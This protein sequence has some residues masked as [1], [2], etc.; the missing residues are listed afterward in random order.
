[1]EQ[2]DAMLR[3]VE[4]ADLVLALI[5]NP[6]YAY[7]GTTF[8][9]G[10]ACALRK[11]IVVLSTSSVRFDSPT[12]ENAALWSSV[13]SKTVFDTESA[14]QFVLKRMRERNDKKIL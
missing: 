8:E 4:S 1:M 12:Y 3:A 5:D 9:L 11:T 7:R 13:I 6:D 14:V 10:A 2:C